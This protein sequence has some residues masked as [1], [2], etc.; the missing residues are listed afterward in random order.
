[1]GCLPSIVMTPVWDR[2]SGPSYDASAYTSSAR[3][4]GFFKIIPSCL[5]EYK[6]SKT[7]LA[8]SRFAADRFSVIRPSRFTWMTISGRVILALNSRL[9]TSAWYTVFGYSSLGSLVCLNSSKFERSDVFPS[10]EWI[11]ECEWYVDS[12]R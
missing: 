11:V 10:L 4:E 1:M 3:F 9:P 8:A 2:D 12:M 6:Y 5:L 7:F